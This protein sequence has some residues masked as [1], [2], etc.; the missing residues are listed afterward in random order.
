MVV[1]RAAEV[2]VEDQR[3]GGGVDLGHKT[4]KGAAPEG[5]LDH[6]SG[7][8]KVRGPSVSSHIGVARAIDLDGESIFIT[9]P[10]QVSQISEQSS[11]GRK[12]DDESVTGVASASTSVD[13][14]QHARGDGQVVGGSEAGGVYRAGAV[15]DQ[16][17]HP[18]TLGP[19]AAHE[20]GIGQ[21]T[22]GGIELAQVAIIGQREPTIEK[23]SGAGGNRE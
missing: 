17:V 6:A 2:G 7:G 21:S 15:H 22:A 14:L 11:G 12:F 3:R 10:A 23:L 19:I 4:V 13:R 8:R 20:C 9:G 1:T 18:V 16:A 5:R